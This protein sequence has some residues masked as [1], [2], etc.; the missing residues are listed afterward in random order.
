MRIGRT[1]LAFLA[2]L[3]VTFVVNSPL[4]MPKFIQ[5]LASSNYANL[6]EAPKLEFHMLAM[7]IHAFL[8]AVIYPMGYR[9]GVPWIEGLRFGVLVALLISLPCALHVFAMVNAPA[10]QQAF[11]VVWTVLVNGIGGIVVGLVHGR[12]AHRSHGSEAVRIASAAA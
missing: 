9:G 7:L 6:R 11:P 2:V 12:D 1:L 4:V 8:L 5:S 10:S 3:A